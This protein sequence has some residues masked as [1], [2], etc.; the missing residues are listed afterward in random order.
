MHALLPDL[1]AECANPVHERASTRG[2]D[3]YSLRLRIGPARVT[4]RHCLAEKRRV[5]M[6]KDRPPWSVTS[7]T[8]KIRAFARA[9]YGLLEVGQ[10]CS[11]LTSERRATRAV[12][13]MA[14]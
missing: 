14:R 4:T 12:N 11:R 13:A 10:T 7:P 1:P 9:S 5:V 8:P 2:W 6:T 3:S